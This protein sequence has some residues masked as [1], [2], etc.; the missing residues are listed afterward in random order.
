MLY[1]FAGGIIQANSAI[2]MEVQKNIVVLFL[3]AGWLCLTWTKEFKDGELLY[4]CNPYA[5]SF[6][7]QPTNLLAKHGDITPR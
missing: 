4:A 2:H 1:D 5:F 7:R 6:G 3:I